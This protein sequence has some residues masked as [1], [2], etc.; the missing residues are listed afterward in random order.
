M[1]KEGLGQKLSIGLRFQSQLGLV[2]AVW[3]WPNHFPSLNPHFLTCRIIPIQGDLGSSPIH[4]S[5]LVNTDAQLF[6]EQLVVLGSKGAMVLD[7]AGLE[8][9]QALGVSK[10]PTG[11]SKVPGLRTAEAGGRHNQGSLA[12]LHL[13]LLKPSCIRTFIH[14]H[15]HSVKY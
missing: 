1:G 8:G 11:D 2:L 14:S 5:Y 6:L 12:F 15:L 4:A 9:G 13:F 3:P 7:S 10:G